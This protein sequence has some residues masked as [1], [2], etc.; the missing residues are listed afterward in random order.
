LQEN[1]NGGGWTTLVADGRTSLGV[2]RV[3]GSCGYRVQACNFVNCG[4]WSGIATVTVSLPP[5][6][7]SFYIA[8]W[9]TT[10]RAPYQVWC[11]AG[12]HPV[13]TATEYQ[14][15]TGGGGKRLYTGPT[16]YVAAAGN[17]YCGATVRVRA[18]NA[19]GCSAWS[20]DYTA[21]RGVY[22]VD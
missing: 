6:T 16:D 7:P 20:P 5:A 9:L 2:S 13:A 4:P 1:A 22:E 21:T 3:N 8:T 10:R 17:A 11:E 18:C 12:W 14:L 19:G 15:E